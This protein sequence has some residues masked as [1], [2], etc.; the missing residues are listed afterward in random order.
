MSIEA[1]V[2]QYIDDKGFKKS[3]I[4]KKADM[5][6]G[7]LTEVARGGRRLRADELMKICRILN[8]DPKEFVTQ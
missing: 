6:A 2:C 4:E 1:S 7:A 8:V 3:F 5:V